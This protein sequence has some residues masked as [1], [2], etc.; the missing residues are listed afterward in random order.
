[1][2]EN[3]NIIEKKIDVLITN[4]NVN[5]CCYFVI[6]NEN[7]KLTNGRFLLMICWEL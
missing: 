6:P 4:Q 5:E 7:I 1:M 2:D 3:L